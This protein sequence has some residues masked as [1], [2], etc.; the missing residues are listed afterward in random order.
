MM[1]LLIVLLVLLLVVI[2]IM[3]FA[4]RNPPSERVSI[5]AI[6]NHPGGF[7]TLLRFLQ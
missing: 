1:V 7:P 2:L 6:G 4:D 5:G 3:L